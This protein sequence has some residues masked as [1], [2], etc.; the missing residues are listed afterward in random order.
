MDVQTLSSSLNDLV[1]LLDDLVAVKDRT[2]LLAFL[3]RMQARVCP[4]ARMTVAERRGDTLDN[5]LNIN[6]SQRWLNFYVAEEFAAV[7]PVANAAPGLV[8]WSRTLEY[9]ARAGRDVARFIQAAKA[10]D[11]YRGITYIVEDGPVRVYLSLSGESTESDVRLHAVLS[12]LMPKLAMVIV[13]VLS[14]P[15][16]VGLTDQ[17]CTILHYM[18]AG[19]TDDETA[20]MV[21]LAPR[22][23]MRKIGDIKNLYG[24][25]SRAQL[26][27]S[28]SGVNFP[29]PRTT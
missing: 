28:L 17:Q 29:L 5:I 19:L 13:R 18:A 11:M 6:W 22:T 10:H 16:L 15:R 3:R 23:V 20:K 12:A 8:I 24:V 25:S 4:D 26:I 9:E 2:T 14:M 27:A 21:G 7:D 1:V